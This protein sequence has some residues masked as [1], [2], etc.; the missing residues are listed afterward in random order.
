MKPIL[1]SVLVISV[2]GSCEKDET[3]NKGYEP[4]TE[5]SV[6]DSLSPSLPYEYYEIRNNNCFDSTQYFVIYSNGANPFTDSLLPMNKGVYYSTGDVCRFN[7]ILTING[8]NLKFCITYSEMLDFLGTIDCKGDAL[9]IAHL[10][11][12][13]FTY[14]DSAYGI[15]EVN[16][17]F[18]IYACKLVSACVPVQVDRFLI[19]IDPRG[20]IRILNQETVSRDENACI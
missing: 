1:F 18:R 9:F 6:F 12:Y 4:I 11:G 10:N 17:K 19:E 15:K 2:L 13:Y 3:D 8:N 16:G 7:N 14:N 20:K 5:Q